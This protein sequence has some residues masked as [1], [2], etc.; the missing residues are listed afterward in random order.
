MSREGEAHEEQS[1]ET[2][3]V[4]MVATTNPIECRIALEGF[5]E[6]L[7]EATGLYVQGIG[8]WN[9]DSLMQALEAGEVDF[10]WLPPLVA[11]RATGRARIVPLVLPVRNGASSYMTALFTKPDGVVRKISDLKGVRAAWVDRQSAAGYIVLRAHLR[12][13][14]I[15]LDDAFGENR[16]Y[17]SHGE[18][19][20]AVFDGEAD[21]GATFVYVEP[22]KSNPTGERVLRAGWGDR[23]VHVITRAGPIPSDVMAASVRVPVA[24]MR[25]V[26]RALTS[27]DDTPVR[28]TALALFGAEGFVVALSE[29]LDPLRKLITV[30]DDP[31]VGHPPSMMPPEG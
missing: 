5:C 26:Q 22:D 25:L 27:K 12:S 1:E 6:A 19:A 9:Y 21:V 8:D 17:G 23:S 30:V 7:S 4:G 2:T 18:V 13:L 28:R 29:H 11:M 20:R 31:P 14:G 3:T 16:F 15:N 10:A 24:T